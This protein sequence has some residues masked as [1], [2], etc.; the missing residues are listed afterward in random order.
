MPAHRLRQLELAVACQGRVRV[1]DHVLRLALAE[2]ELGVRLDHARAERHDATLTVTLTGSAAFCEAF[3][4]RL[5]L[6]D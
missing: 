5:E 3:R 1:L 6:G 4:E 2:L